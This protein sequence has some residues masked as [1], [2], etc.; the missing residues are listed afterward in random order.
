[1]GGLQLD[2]DAQL[3]GQRFGQLDFEAAQLAAFVDKAER[4]VGAFQADLDLAGLLIVSVARR[5]PPGPTTGSQSQTQSAHQQVRR[6]RNSHEE[7]L[8]FY[9]ERSR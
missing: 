5:Q 3:L 8:C 6:C 1:M 4:R 9:V 2:L 7:P